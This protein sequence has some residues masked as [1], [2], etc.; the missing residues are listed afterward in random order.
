MLGACGT[1]HPSA[2][3]AAILSHKGREE[4]APYFGSHTLFASPS[5]STLQNAP[6]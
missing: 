5:N 6:P 1:P 2:L 3:R 4:I